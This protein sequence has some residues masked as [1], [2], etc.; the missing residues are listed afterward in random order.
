MQVVLNNQQVYHTSKT[1][2][3]LDV[4]TYLT[5]DPKVGVQTFQFP[6]H[7][8]LPLMPHW[9]HPH[10]LPQQR[11]PFSKAKLCMVQQLVRQDKQAAIKLCK[12]SQR[13]SKAPIELVLRDV[14]IWALLQRPCRPALSYE[15]LLHVQTGL[16]VRH[17]DK[18]LNKGFKVPVFMKRGT[19]VMS[20]AMFKLFGWG[21]EVDKAASASPQAAQK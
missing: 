10:C 3:D 9:T 4:N 1:T 12:I 15:V 16:I 20:S 2:I 5:I 13:S 14:R 11:M 8:C 21:K 18:W 6:E 7:A 17:E 19:G